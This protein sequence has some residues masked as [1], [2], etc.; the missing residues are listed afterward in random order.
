[1]PVRIQLKRSKGWRMPPDTLKVDRT[2][3][4]GNPF[5]PQDCGST[6]AA[7]RCYEAWLNGAKV[8]AGCPSVAAI[9]PTR[10]EIRRVLAGHNLACW[11]PVGS[12]CHGDILLRL[13]NG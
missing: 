10:A 12:P 8:P 4:W 1:M 5:T 13:A 9:P 6:A 11:C 7:V 3:R 2:T